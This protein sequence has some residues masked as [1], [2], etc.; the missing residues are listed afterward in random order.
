M[1]HELT[2]GLVDTVTCGEKD[3]IPQR[4]GLLGR[5]SAVI[6]LVSNR[7]VAKRGFLTSLR[8]AL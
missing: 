5:I 6:R 3:N 7:G 4:I 1:K 8:C 2:T